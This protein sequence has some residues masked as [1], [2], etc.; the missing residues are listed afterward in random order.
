MYGCLLPVIICQQNWRESHDFHP[1]CSTF[2]S[3]VAKLVP[4]QKVADRGKHIH[5]MAAVRSAVPCFLLFHDSLL[6]AHLTVKQLIVVFQ[7]EKLPPREQSFRHSVFLL[8]WHRSMIC[9]CHYI[10][11][12]HWDQET[13][14]QSR[15]QR[16]GR[17]LR[18]TCISRRMSNTSPF[19]K[20]LTFNGRILETQSLLQNMIT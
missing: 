5:E 18:R 3:L 15:D 14:T 4:Q 16:M 17:R 12:L 10:P 8:M 9:R 7:L 1:R 11:D 19:F 13:V 20:N 2:P 6:S